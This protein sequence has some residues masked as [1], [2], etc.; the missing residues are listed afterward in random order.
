MHVMPVEDPLASFDWFDWGLYG[1]NWR[2]PYGI[3]VVKNEL[4]SGQ[5]IVALTTNH[6]TGRIEKFCVNS[7]YTSSPGWCRDTLIHTEPF[8]VNIYVD[9]TSG[10]A[11]YSWKNGTSDWSTWYRD[12]TDYYP[13]LRHID[14]D[15]EFNTPLEGG[16]KTHLAVISLAYPSLTYSH[17]ELYKVKMQNTGD[18][19]CL[20]DLADHHY[21]CIDN[22]KYNLEGIYRSWDPVHGISGSVL[23]IDGNDY[24]TVFNTCGEY[25]FWN[26]WA[27]TQL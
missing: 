7:I 15:Y 1:G 14:I 12:G 17:V 19:G 22:L 20:Q 16:A 4:V 21:Y 27:D 9:S 23:T 24:Y 3:G 2:A 8:K 26:A 11:D 10:P 18:C 13:T 6:N 5:H 25:N